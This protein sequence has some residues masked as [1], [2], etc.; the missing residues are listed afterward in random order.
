M[1]L[2]AHLENSIVTE[3]VGHTNVISSY[4]KDTFRTEVYLPVIDCLLGE[5]KERFSIESSVMRGIQ[6]L[7]PKSQ[8]FLDNKIL[9]DMATKYDVSTED[10]VHEVPHTA[11][12][13]GRK[14][15]EGIT[16]VTLQQ[17]AGFM[18]P[19]KDYSYALFQLITIAIV[20]PVSKVS[21]ERSFSQNNAQN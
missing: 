2:L 4:T 8:T 14:A 1:R 17:L 6:C 21:C 11:R 15:A 18:Q 3:T 10:L 12:L 20:L 5:L 13:L 16:V 9:Q 19:Y 7:D